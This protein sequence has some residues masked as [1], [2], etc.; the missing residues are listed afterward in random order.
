MKTIGCDKCQRCTPPI[1]HARYEHAPSAVTPSLVSL[2]GRPLAVFLFIGSALRPVRFSL[3]CVLKSNRQ[4]VGSK[5]TSKLNFSSQ[6][7]AKHR[8]VAR[9]ARANDKLTR[10]RSHTRSRRGS[11]Q[12][13]ISDRRKT[14]ITL[15]FKRCPPLTKSACP[16]NRPPACRL[17]VPFLRSRYSRSVGKRGEERHRAFD[18]V[19]RVRLRVPREGPGARLFRRYLDHQDKVCA[20]A[21]G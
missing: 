20:V 17:T 1:P 13:A 9:H 2:A 10:L 21:S 12:Q 6:Q 7:T 14:G 3:T 19:R 11:T 18:P 5:V 8:P 4:R 15:R 16:T